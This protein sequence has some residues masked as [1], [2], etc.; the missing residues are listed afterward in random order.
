ML[1]LY[2]KYR[3]KT[4]DDVIGQDNIIKSLKGSITTGKISHAYLFTGPRGTGKTS[5]ARILAHEI[6]GFKYEL[7]DSYLDIIE[8]DAASNTGVDNIRELREKA[9]IAPS[10][11]K[12]KVY[13]IDEVHML[14]K[15]AF[16]ALLKTL[17]EPPEHTIFILATTDIEKVPITITSRSQVY[18]FHLAD[19][20]TMLDFLKTVSKKEKINISDDALRITVSRGGGS[21]RDSLS[22]L[23]QIS[24]LG[25]DKKEITEETVSSALGLPRDSKLSALLESY[26]NNDFETITTL[27]KECLT[28]GLKPE[29]IAEECIRKILS[30]PNPTL[31]P[32]LE[33]LPTVSAP[34][35]EAKLLLAFYQPTQNIVFSSTSIS[36]KHTLTP[37][38]PELKARS[39]SPKE[40]PEKNVEISKEQV[41]TQIEFNWSSYLDA[42]KLANP[43][44]HQQLVKCSYKLENN[45]LILFSEKKIIK[46]ILTRKNNLDIL[47]TNLPQN[48]SIEINDQNDSD[49]EN[50]PYLTKI[51]DIMGKGIKEVKDNGGIPF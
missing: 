18:N 28:E 30:K 14:S 21:F 10:Q 17:E 5:V 25:T 49:N 23:D 13:I 45:H 31:F 44:I 7:E 47:T 37:I 51:S 12:Y 22:L 42:I 48:Y 9:I 15:S 2:R 33:K 19:E 50:D 32:L 43:A 16:N 20:K 36:E 35:P 24:T 8:I 11:G 26:Q 6:N 29:S 34:F 39:K 40:K 27:I 4:L 1:A 3:P 38:K 46:T 41:K